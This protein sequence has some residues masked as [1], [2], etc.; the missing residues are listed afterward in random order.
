HAN[1]DA[2]RD[3]DQHWF[4]NNKIDIKQS[5]TPSLDVINKTGNLPIMV[6]FHGDDGLMGSGNRD[7]YGPE[8]FLDHNRLETTD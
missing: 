8:F 2:K 7:N 6:Y 5:N 3:A 1:I 4:C